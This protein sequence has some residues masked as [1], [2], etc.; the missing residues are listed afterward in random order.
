VNFEI[1]ELFR[2]VKYDV[3]E[4]I[5]MCYMRYGMM[6]KCDQDIV[7]SR[8]KISCWDLL[9]GCIDLWV[10]CEWDDPDSTDIMDSQSWSYSVG[11]SRRRFIWLSPRFERTDQSR[12]IGFTLSYEV[13]RWWAIEMIM[14][15]IV[16]IHNE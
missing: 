16:W 13:M 4:C 14:C 15:M 6:W 8:K 10:Y 3:I 5:L 7:F 9:L 2:K 11:E 12:S 1:F